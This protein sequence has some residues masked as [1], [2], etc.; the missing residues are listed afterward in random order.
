MECSHDVFDAAL[1]CVYGELNAI[2][3]HRRSKR[4]A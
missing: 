3:A 4:S 1:S 2:H